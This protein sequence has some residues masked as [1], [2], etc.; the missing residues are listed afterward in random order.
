MLYPRHLAAGR[1]RPQTQDVMKYLAF[2]GALVTAVFTGLSMAF[3]PGFK[4]MSLVGLGS[5]GV[6][7]F[8]I[9]I[10][11]AL[12]LLLLNN[13][14]RLTPEPVRINRYVLWLCFAYLLY[15]LVIVL[16]VAVLSYGMRPVDVERALTVRLAIILVP[17]FYSIVL[18]YWKPSV[19]IAMFDAV[20]VC[21]AVWV[22]YQ[23]AT[24]GGSGYWDGGVY[25]LRAA[26]GG[27]TL[28]FAWLV[29]TSLF[30]WPLRLWRAALAALGAGAL[31]VVDHRSGIVALAAAILVLLV[32]MRGVTRRAV[33]A[34]GVFA[35][36][37]VA[38]VYS[39]PFVRTSIEYTFRT[40]VNPSADVNASDRITRPILALDYFQQHPWG[41]FIW[42]QTYYLVN[43][44]KYSY[45][46]HNFPVQL[47]VTQG[48]IA[49]LLYLA[50]VIITIGLAWRN[51]NHAE[52]AVMLAYLTFY[53]VFCLFNTN[54]DQI[55]NVALL[56]VPMALI[57]DVHRRAVLAAGPAVP[58]REPAAE[59]GNR[60]GVADSHARSRVLSRPP[61]KP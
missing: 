53:L 6:T 45:G 38:V 41:D 56:Y 54:I 44:G 25:R 49:T 15:Q 1:R 23:V 24:S 40:L 20:A 43:L 58:E 5:V 46:P 29:F 52:G 55:E 9:I 60:L 13:A 27:T 7:P 39:S 32:A 42:N 8:D 4:T 10:G 22:L 50:P 34:V 11:G 14:L 28:L 37:G 33:L 51:R 31:L 61:R 17:F 59:E 16:P 18:Q 21:L 35:V 57:L 12:F 48:T 47:L 2:I 3:Q 36:L 26:W 19:V 30:Y